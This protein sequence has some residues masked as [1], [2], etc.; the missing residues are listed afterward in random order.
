MNVQGL[1]KA[2][3]YLKQDITGLL[4]DSVCQYKTSMNVQADRELHIP[5]LYAVSN[6]QKQSVHFLLVAITLAC[7]ILQYSKSLFTIISTNPMY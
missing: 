4:L 1:S 6:K 3:L 7:F 5:V 2:T